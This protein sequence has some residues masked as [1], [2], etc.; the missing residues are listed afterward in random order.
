MTFEA[1][2]NA[3]RS[4]FKTQVADAL[5]L[6]TQ[7]DNQG[8]DNPDNVTWCRLTVKPGQTQQVSIGSPG[9]N[10]DRTPG[11]AIAQLFCPIGFGDGNLLN[12]AD[13]VR[14]AFRRVSQ[15]GVVFRTPYIQTV[16]QRQDSWQINVVC[17]F[18]ADDI[19]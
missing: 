18:Y 12:V 14:T 15:S 9:A 17:P 16:G 7:Y 13:S 11:V 5:S 8:R 19:G 4:R 2:A 3:I 6:D 10:R 1:M